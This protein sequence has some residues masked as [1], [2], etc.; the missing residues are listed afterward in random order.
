MLKPATYFFYFHHCA[1]QVWV[2][3]RER[4]EKRRWSCK[5]L[6]QGAT[7]ERK[8]SCVYIYTVYINIYITYYTVYGAKVNRT[9]LDFNFDSFFHVLSEQ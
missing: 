5:K 8:W 6:Q 3:L 1:N 7:A 9:A 4:E 2:V